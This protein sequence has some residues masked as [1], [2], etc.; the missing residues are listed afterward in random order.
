MWVLPVRTDRA[1]TY[2][3]MRS[4]KESL[5]EPPKLYIVL[6]VTEF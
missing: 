2:M 3:S 4:I 1:C 6:C 5:K